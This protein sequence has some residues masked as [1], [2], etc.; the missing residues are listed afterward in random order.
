MS[1]LQLNGLQLDRYL[2]LK[3]QKSQQLHMFLLITLFLRWVPKKLSLTPVCL[4]FGNIARYWKKQN[5]D[6]PH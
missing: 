4:C 6:S 5:C 2:A 3:C 1:G